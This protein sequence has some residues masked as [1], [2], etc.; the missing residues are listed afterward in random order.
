MRWSFLACGLVLSA[1]SDGSSSSS[2]SSSGGTVSDC[3]Y[4][5][6]LS[7]GVEGTID[8]NGCATGSDG[9]FSLA[10]VNPSTNRNRGIRITLVTPLKGG[11]LGP[12]PLESVTIFERLEDGSSTL[13]WSS[14]SCSIELTKNE[15]APTEV[16]ENR[17]VIE[18]KGSCASPLAPVA[19]NTRAPVT[20]APFEFGAFINPR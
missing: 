6:T 15:S 16:S 3:R 4:S 5:G 1:C 17:Y 8:V 7:G 18:G 19:P 2:S 12:Q 14:T 20:V 9:T 13:E 11:E 10:E